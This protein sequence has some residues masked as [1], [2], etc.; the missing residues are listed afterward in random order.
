MAPALQRITFHCRTMYRD[1]GLVPATL[2]VVQPVRYVPGLYRG[3]HPP[4]PLP[5]GIKATVDF[6]TVKAAAFDLPALPHP[7]ECCETV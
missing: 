5:G 6:S 1:A 2:Q 7:M 3:T 4:T